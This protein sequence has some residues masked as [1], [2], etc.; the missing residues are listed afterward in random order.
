MHVHEAMND[1]EPGARI[2]ECQPMIGASSTNGCELDETPFANFN[3][4]QESARR[5]QIDSSANEGGADE[6]NS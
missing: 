5:R 1:N 2:A 6:K 4:A 3:R